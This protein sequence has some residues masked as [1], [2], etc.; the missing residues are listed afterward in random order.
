M[1]I[2]KGENKMKKIIALLLAC[3][4]MLSLVAC[5]NGGDNGDDNDDTAAFFTMT[6]EQY[7]NVKTKSEGVMNYAEY[8]AAE[9][10]SDVVIEAYVQAT[11]SWW[12]NKITVYLADLD[13]AY[14]AYEMACS[15]ADAAKLT[16][17]TKIKVSGTKVEWAG[18]VELGS[19]ATFEFV[20]A[21]N[22]TFIAP[23]FD[24]TA[25]L[26]KDSLV[27]YQNRLVAYKG[28]TIKSIEYKNGEPGDDIW[29]TVTKDNVDYALTVEIYLTGKDTD[30]YK[31]FAD[32]KANDKVNIEGFLYWYNGV[33]THITKVTKVG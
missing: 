23:V 7:K 18:E 20:G 25:L 13:G 31:A 3:I 1:A 10:N 11:Q 12:D 21:A 9:L 32:L 22:D 16:P 27:K 5:V 17:G 8:I 2:K 28:V 19:G 24:A 29:V 14:F 30:V 6:E 15:E 33:D 26:G 4:T